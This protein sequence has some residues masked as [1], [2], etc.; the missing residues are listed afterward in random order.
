MQQL[1]KYH[2]MI[3]RK[4]EVHVPKNPGSKNQPSP[5]S[6]N[7]KKTMDNHLQASAHLK[8]AAEH[9]LDAAR[10]YAEGNLEK[11]EKSAKLAWG[12]HAIAG[13]FKNDDAKHHA[14]MLKRTNYR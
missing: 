14:Q 11:A 6:V 2:K 13:E 5:I 3:N 7:N 4:K 8:E 1:L 10:F 9:H 12:Q